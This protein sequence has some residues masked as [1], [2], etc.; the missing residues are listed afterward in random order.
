MAQTPWSRCLVT[1]ILA[2][3]Q[4]I[5]ILPFTTAEAAS[6]ALQYR[7]AF[8]G[9]WAIREQ[10]CPAGAISCS[11]NHCCPANTACRDNL[12][13][14]YCCPTREWKSRFLTPV[15]RLIVLGMRRKRLLAYSS[16]IPRLRG[17]FLGVV[18]SQNSQHLLLLRG[19][20]TRDL[21]T[22]WRRRGWVL[23]CKWHV[24]SHDAD[25]FLGTTPRTRCPL[26]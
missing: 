9:G 15:T 16:I 12:G 14:G 4:S 17:P 20:R 13:D 21:C 6:P 2:L 5:S 11:G 10:Q 1:L 23:R 18:H 24:R 25:C 19:W 22:P 8:T 26:R 7:A 3:L